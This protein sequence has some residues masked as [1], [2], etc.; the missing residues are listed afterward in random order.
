VSPTAA[1]GPDHGESAPAISLSRV[2]FPDP[3]LPPPHP[4][5]SETVRIAL[6]RAPVDPSHG[7]Q[8]KIHEDRQ[9]YPG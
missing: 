5:A 6:R 4:V 8:L 2:D 3:L 7:H 1:D 9:R